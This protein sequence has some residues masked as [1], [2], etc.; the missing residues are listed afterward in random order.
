MHAFV[1]ADGEEAYENLR[2]ALLEANND[3]KAIKQQ[4]IIVN[5]QHHTIK[6]QWVG[7]MKMTN[8]IFGLKSA[9]ANHACFFCE[10]HMDQ[11]S[12]LEV[13]G[14]PRD[15]EKRY[16]LCK[17]RQKALGYTAL[18]PLLC[19]SADEIVIDELHFVL[20]M[21]GAILKRLRELVLQDK[22]KLTSAVV[23]A[24]AEAGLTLRPGS[25]ATLKAT[26]PFKK[27]NTLKFLGEVDWSVC[28]PPDAACYMENLTHLFMKIYW[29][30]IE[31]ESHKESHLNQLVHDFLEMFCQDVISHSPVPM[32]ADIPDVGIR[33][34]RF[35]HGPA[36][37]T[38]SPPPV[39][40][41]H[42]T[43]FLSEHLISCLKRG[44]FKVFSCEST[45]GKNFEHM[46]DF[47]RCT[48]RGGDAFYHI[49]VKSLVLFDMRR[50]NIFL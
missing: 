42:Y 12:D 18:E 4:G 26:N 31:F 28:L 46:T 24:F 20:R 37:A 3:I 17:T 41:T 6:F 34:V 43:H 2:P 27:R 16:N 49:I 39:K 50:Q 5:G 32:L 47:F 14:V 30:S 25:L 45:E 23:F 38:S 21:G 8:I 15:F 36:E 7:D 9:R 10:K 35:S 11:Y 48:N 44:N 19:L 22:T 29:N 33:R 40:P 13:K 1:I